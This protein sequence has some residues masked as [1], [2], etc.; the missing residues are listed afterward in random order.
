MVSISNWFCN[1]KRK[2][3][4]M[5][6]KISILML[7]WQSH[8]HLFMQYGHFDTTTAALSSWNSGHGKQPWWWVII[9]LRLKRS[10]H[11]WFID[12]SVISEY[13]SEGKVSNVFFEKCIYFLCMCECLH[14]FMSHS[15]AWCWYRSVEGIR[16]PGVRVPG[17]YEPL[18]M[19]SGMEVESCKSNKGL[20]T[21]MFF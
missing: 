20:T 1:L 10:D 5:K 17:S 2:I 4:L 11:A 14:V 6:N 13:S 18:D 12:F 21:G 3:R 7:L 9:R 8:V 16:F 19:G 15:H